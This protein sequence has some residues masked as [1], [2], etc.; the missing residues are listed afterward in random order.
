MAPSPPRP[1]RATQ[2]TASFLGEHDTRQPRTL[3]STAADIGGGAGAGTTGTGT[4]GGGVGVGGGGGGGAGGTNARSG[5]R[6]AGA[7]VVVG[8]SPS[9]GNTPSRGGRVREPLVPVVDLSG[10]LFVAPTTA[11]RGG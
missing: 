8:A 3:A 6:P 9:R 5:L 11:D 7:G 2:S 10:M 4:T 1:T